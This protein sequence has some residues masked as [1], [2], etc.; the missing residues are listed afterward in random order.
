M[1]GFDL[2]RAIRDARLATE[3]V[4][5][6][7]Y[8]DEEIFNS[9]MDLGVKSYVLKDSAITEIVGSIKAVA[10]GRHFISPALSGYLINRNARAA[11]LVQHTPGLRSLTP[12]ERRI[13]KFIAEYKTS[14]EI[15]TQLHI[16]SRT[17]DNHRTNICQK[18]DLHGSHARSSSPSNTSQKYRQ[19][20]GSDTWRLITDLTYVISLIKMWVLTL[21]E[22]VTHSIHLRNHSAHTTPRS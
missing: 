21:A 11:L 18:L 15:A 22:S 9:A 12:T 10:A 16:H 19:V 7:M 3:I 20:T 2:V 17:V 4:F 8:D 13:L 5:L 1:A 6:T 14:K